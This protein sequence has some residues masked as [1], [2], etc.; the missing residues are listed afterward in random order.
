M[1]HSII[2]NNRFKRRTFLKG[3]LVGYFVFTLTYFPKKLLA[4]GSPRPQQSPFATPTF[5]ALAETIIP[6]HFSDPN[7]T[8]G[9]IE[10]GTI[11]Y[12]ERVEKAGVL[13][14]SLLSIQGWVTFAL[15]TYSL[16]TRGA[17]FANLG[18]NQ[19]VEVA[20][21]FYRLMPVPLLYRLFRATYYT[22]AQNRLGWDNLGYPGPNQGYEDYSFKETL[23]RSDPRSMDGNLP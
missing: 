1:I 11:E 4:A 6:G 2:E 5:I 18:A 9:A 19:K 16:F 3:S 23:A 22:G 17:T 20:S 21:D 10:T 13:P 14:F 15:D 7:G 12:L 8:P